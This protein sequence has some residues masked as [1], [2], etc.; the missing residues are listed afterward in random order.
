[1]HLR[2]MTWNLQAG[3]L[4]V[5]KWRQMFRACTMVVRGD[6]QVCLFLLPYA[7]Y[8]AVAQGAEAAASDIMAEVE[9]VLEGG[10]A[11]RE[12]ELCVQAVFSLLDVLKAW[13]EQRKRG[14]ASSAHSAGAGEAE[15]PSPMESS[16]SDWSIVLLCA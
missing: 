5:G 15:A 2:I 1:M 13:L 9:A 14:A 11:S 16:S 6:I 8:N 3:L 4:W 12:G 10:H 7:V